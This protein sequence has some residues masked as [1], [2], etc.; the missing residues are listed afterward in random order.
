MSQ[1]KRFKIKIT[2]TGTIIMDVTAQ[3]KKIAVETAFNEIDTWSENEFIENLDLI[4]SGV[5]IKHFVDTESE[6]EDADPEP[7]D[8]DNEIKKLLEG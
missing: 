2:Y 7:D 1:E 4:V 6:Y 8:N 5:G 3:D